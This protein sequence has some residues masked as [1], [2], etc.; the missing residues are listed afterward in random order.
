MIKKGNSFLV[1]YT[2]DLDKTENFY[3]ELD[4]EIS[5]RNERKLV[6]KIGDLE[7]HF[8][9]DEPIKEYASNFS[10]S[11]RGAGII[12]GI[13]I[14]NV[15]QYYSKLKSTNANILSSIIKAPWE[16]REFLVNDPNGYHIV[17]WQEI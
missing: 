6:F 3:K 5:E 13:E 17:F 16:T 10:Q 7:L 1:L 4:V 8:N 2:N 15:D 14:D 9:T 11:P 12:F